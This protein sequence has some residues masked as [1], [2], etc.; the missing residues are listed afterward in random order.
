M[1]PYTV[2][3]FVR[4]DKTLKNRKRQGRW[5]FAP[6]SLPADRVKIPNPQTQPNAVTA[7]ERYPNSA[8]S[9][10]GRSPAFGGG[11]GRERAFRTELMPWKKDGAAEK[12][13]LVLVV[14]L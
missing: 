14:G 13:T 3:Q 6:P 10:G 9:G 7:S 5:R 4:Q 8:G 11:P 12:G 2:K 1:S